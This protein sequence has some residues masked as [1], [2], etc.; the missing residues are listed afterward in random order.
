MSDRMQLSF[1]WLCL[2]DHWG[3]SLAFLWTCKY[4]G[5]FLYCK[6]YSLVYHSPMDIIFYLFCFVYGCSSR[7]EEPGWGAIQLYT[8]AICMEATCHMWHRGVA[9]L[10]RHKYLSYMIDCYLWHV[11]QRWL[12]N[13][14]SILCQNWQSCQP[15]PSTSARTI[16]KWR[17]CNCSAKH[18]ATMLWSTA[19]C[20]TCWT[21]CFCHYPTLLMVEI[22][23]Y[24]SARVHG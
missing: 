16:G 15:V 11:T 2:V 9:L 6:R 5:A 10:K 23:Q 13:Y 17:L 18:A 14:I 8:V 1:I 19:D 12:L 7:V 20:W 21:Q 24:I 22:V 4:S 3:D